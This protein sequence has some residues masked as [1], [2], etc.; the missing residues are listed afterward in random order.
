MGVVIGHG[1]QLSVVLS[2]RLWS[3]IQIGGA[4]AIR[5][6]SCDGYVRRFVSLVENARRVQKSCRE[7]PLFEVLKR[8]TRYW[9]IVLPLEY[10]V[11]QRYFLITDN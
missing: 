4:V 8:L 11:L 6:K 3:V 1:G 7:C 2:S 9:P 10:V 5:A